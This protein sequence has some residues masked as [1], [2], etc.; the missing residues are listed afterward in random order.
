[1][2]HVRKVLIIPLV[3]NRSIVPYQRNGN[4]SL[5]TELVRHEWL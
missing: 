3:T 2:A 1:M 5:G 4:F